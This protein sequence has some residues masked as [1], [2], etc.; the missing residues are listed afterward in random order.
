MV[1]RKPVKKLHTAFGYGPMEERV[2]EEIDPEIEDLV[3]DL[4]RAG[5]RTGYSCA[6]GFGHL[7]PTCEIYLSTP[8]KLTKEDLDSIVGIIRVHTNIPIRL[9]LEHRKGRGSSLGIWFRGPMEGLL[10]D[11]L[12]DVRKRGNV[13]ESFVE[14]LDRD[15]DVLTDEDL[16]EKVMRDDTFWDR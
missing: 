11:S 9:D 12:E 7:H 14:S 10:E 16:L 13:M 5:Y 15:D 4:N 8:F 6:G 2:R 1:I 3:L